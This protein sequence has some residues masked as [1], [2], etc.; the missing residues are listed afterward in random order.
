MKY[1]RF[2]RDQTVGSGESSII[3]EL[4]FGGIL[5]LQAGGDSNMKISP[6]YML[7]S[8]YGQLALNDMDEALNAHP[9]VAQNLAKLFSDAL[10]EWRGKVKELELSLSEK[11]ALLTEISTMAGNVDWLSLGDSALTV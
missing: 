7:S 6:Y 1:K 3:I 8:S 10:T 5:K 9:D 4:V 11:N 2:L